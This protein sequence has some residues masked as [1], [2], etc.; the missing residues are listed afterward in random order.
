ML[1]NAISRFDQPMGRLECVGQA[2][3]YPMVSALLV[4]YR[5]TTV[6]IRHSVIHG[7]VPRLLEHDF[8]L[9]RISTVPEPE[10][11]EF[12]DSL[13]QIGLE[14]VDPGEPEPGVGEDD[15]VLVNEIANDGLETS[16]LKNNGYK[17]LVPNLYNIPAFD[18]SL[19]YNEN[20]A[21]EVSRPVFL[22]RKNEKGEETKY[23]GGLEPIL[24]A[25]DVDQQDNADA[26][27]YETDEEFEGS[28]SVCFGG[29]GK[30]L[31][32]LGLSIFLEDERLGKVDEQITGE[33]DEK[34]LA[35]RPANADLKDD[36]QE[37]D[38]EKEKIGEVKNSQPGAAFSLVLDL[39]VAGRKPLGKEEDE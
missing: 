9:V 32:C 25:P 14:Y 26:E 20:S 38:N 7:V 2:P 34:G 21:Q 6:L 22:A 23:T 36:R 39:F 35:D 37:V 8:D 17:I 13:L 16:D 28:R 30:A 3:A 33:D 18:L 11:L 1:P 19:A 15:V 10:V 24:E 29:S 31:D 27:D 12:A 5:K 4:S